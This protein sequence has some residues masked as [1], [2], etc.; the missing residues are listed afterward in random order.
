M[1]VGILQW[2]GLLLEPMDKSSLH[3]GRTNIAPTEENYLEFGDFE[4]FVE[5]EGDLCEY[6][7]KMICRRGDNLFNIAQLIVKRMFCSTKCKIK[8][9]YARQE[10]A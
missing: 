2:A 6:C 5:E 9:I 10:M 8:W 4:D 7:G 3:F 1:S